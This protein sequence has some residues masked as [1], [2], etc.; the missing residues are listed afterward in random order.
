MTEEVE[1][2]KD[3]EICLTEMDDDRDVQNG[4]W[5]EITQTNHLELQQIPQKL[6]NRKS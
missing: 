4:I 3:Y 5:V 6:V 1:V 2:G